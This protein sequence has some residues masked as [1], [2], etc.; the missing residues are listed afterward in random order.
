MI[1]CYPL[2]G[3]VGCRLDGLELSRELTS[4]EAE[5]VR[6][7]W[8]EYGLV[9]I[10]NPAADDAA[11]MRLSRLF[12]EM[13]PSATADLNDP[14]NRFIFKYGA[15]RRALEQNNAETGAMR[16]VEGP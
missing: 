14:D 15:R 2:P 4:A 8:I 11:Q 16:V 3:G 7:A 6:D 12:G 9:L 10:R 5:A 1:E 13:E